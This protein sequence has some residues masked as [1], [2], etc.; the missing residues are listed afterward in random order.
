MKNL[1]LILFVLV[2][3]FGNAQNVGVNNANLSNGIA[4][5]GFDVVSYFK[6][7]KALK[8]KK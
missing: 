1:F 5:Q 7:N 2:S 6:E 3:T 4:V 8:G